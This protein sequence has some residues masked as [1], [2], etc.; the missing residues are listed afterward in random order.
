[1]RRRLFTVLSVLS[2]AVCVTTVVL[3]V[4]S[5]AHYDFV[6]RSV[7]TPEL[8]ATVFE[9]SSGEGVIE[10]ATAHYDSM[11]DSI[12]RHGSHATWSLSSE[13]ISLAQAEL[14]NQFV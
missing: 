11:D 9:V 10:F 1:M 5:Y 7:E 8:I 2:L 4:R 14:H 13:P 6:V 12:R 3:W